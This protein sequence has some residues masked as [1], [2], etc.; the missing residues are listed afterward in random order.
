MIRILTSREGTFITQN[1][2]RPCDEPFPTRLAR[3]ATTTKSMVFVAEIERD[4]CKDTEVS[5]N[6]HFNSIDKLNKFTR[7]LTYTSQVHNRD[8]DFQRYLTIHHARNSLEGSL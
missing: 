5:I 8:F 1:S 7:R 3:Q 4:S 6:R 2:F